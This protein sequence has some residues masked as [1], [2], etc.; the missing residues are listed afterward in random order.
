MFSLSTFVFQFTIQLHRPARNAYK[1]D[2]MSVLSLSFFCL[3]IRALATRDWEG[4]PNAS[5][6][7]EPTSQSSFKSTPAHEQSMHCVA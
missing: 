1:A 2:R 6:M 7:K 5:L 3:H 4:L